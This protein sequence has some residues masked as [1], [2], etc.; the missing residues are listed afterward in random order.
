MSPEDPVRPFH[1]KTPP[2]TEARGQE[3]ADAVAAVMK[4]AAERDAASRVKTRPRS[5][6]RWALPVGVNL[7]VLALYL[8]VF[9]PDWVTVRPIPAPDPAARV[10]SLR[11]AMYIQMKQI[12]AYRIANGRLPATLAEAGTVAPGVDY[13]PQGTTYLLIATAGETVLRYE[14]SQSA[15]DFVGSAAAKLGG[16]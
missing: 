5:P 11:L 2:S 7:G 13:V 8:L 10:E 1:A 16:G 4:H 6:S 3:A 15:D 9:T 12:E 14:S